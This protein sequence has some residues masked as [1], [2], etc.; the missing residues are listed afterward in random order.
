[1]RVDHEHRRVYVRQSSL[2]DMLICPERSRLKSVL[3]DF[4]TSTDATVMGTSVHHGIEMILNGMDVVSAKDE[5]LHMF[6]DLKSKGFKQTNLD[7]EKYEG[8]IVSMMDAF[9]GGILPDVTLGGTTEW[10]FTAPLGIYVDGYEVMLEGT[11]DYIDPDGVI[12]DWKTASRPYNG[13][14]KQSTSV[15]ASVYAQ[16]AVANNMAQFPVEF[17]FGVMLRQDSPKAQIVYLQRNPAHIE[18]LKSIVEPNIRY[19]LTIGLNHSWMRNDTGALCSDKWCSHWS[20]CKGAHISPQDLAIP[21]I[22][23][24]ISVDS[25]VGTV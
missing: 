21:T 7:P 8:H 4:M 1:M 2:G 19:A 15:Q 9:V 23:V 13:K 24:T 11:M 16:A 22:P 20:V 10:R 14:D 12:W 17:R 18:W 25:S 3:P 6:S 5:A